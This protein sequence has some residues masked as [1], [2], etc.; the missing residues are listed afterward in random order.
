MFYGIKPCCK[1]SERVFGMMKYKQIN[2][3]KIP[4]TGKFRGFPPCKM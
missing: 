3:K 2:N 1:L 4:G